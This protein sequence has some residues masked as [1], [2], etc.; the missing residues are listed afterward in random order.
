MIQQIRLENFKCF[1]DQAIEIGGLT[2]LAGLNGMGKSTVLQ[3]L[4]LLRQSA[5][6]GDMRAQ[7]LLLNGDLIRLGTGRDVLYEHAQTDQIGL[8]L[9]TENNK[10]YRWVFDA[11]GLNNDILPLDQGTDIDLSVSLFSSS[12]Q[13][14]AAER[15]GP[16]DIYDSSHYHVSKLEDVRPDGSYAVSFLDEHSSRTVAESLRHPN[17]LNATLLAQ[18]E[19]WLGELAPG[20]RLKARQ[21]RDVH[22]ASLDFEFIQGQARSQSFRPTNVG[23]GISYALPIILA[24][25]AADRGYLVLV[26]NPES[27][28][29]PQGQLAMGKLLAMAASAGIQVIIETHSDHV[30]NGIRIEVKKGT[31][32]PSAVRMHFFERA[33]EGIRI[34]HRVKSPQ[35]DGDGRIDSWPEGFF[36][37]WD[38]ALD[39]LLG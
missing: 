12:F 23:F 15:I 32:A 33:S 27:H 1:E 18:S 30:L 37:Q 29:H 26:E 5:L 31:L 7:G 25:L 34:S 20:I 19:A 11:T 21:L 24:L 3:A 2:L 13:Y 17:G 4:L 8:N 28:L 6:N 9:A 14:V 38:L 22:R 36:D 39:A 16:R 35:I 10:R